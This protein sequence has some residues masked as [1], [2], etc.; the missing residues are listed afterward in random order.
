MAQDPAKIEAVLELIEGGMSER[1]ACAEIGINRL[2]FRSAVIKVKAVDHYAR[3]T[4]A[5]ARDQVE[6]L[7]ETID[8]MR[9]GTIPVDVARVEIEARKWFASKLWKPT[10]GER[11][12][13]TG[14]DG[15]ALQIE[16]RRTLDVRNLT[17]DQREQLRA[18][19]EAAQRPA[20]E[21]PVTDAEYE[22]VEGGE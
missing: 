11:L 7:E 13:V 22:E 19:I 18:L 20:I 16:Q 6:K 3:A 15:G 4:E 9:A 14:A 10:W 12:A 5:L 1:A 8:E 21:G 17:V 2:T